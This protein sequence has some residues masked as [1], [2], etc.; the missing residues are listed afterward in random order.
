EPRSDRC[1][2]VAVLDPQVRT[3]VVLKV[4]PDRIVVGD[5]VSRHIII[6]ILRLHIFGGPADDDCKLTLIMHES[7]VVRPGRCAPVTD[8]SIRP[9]QK[10]QR[11]FRRILEG[12]LRRMVRIIETECENGLRHHRRQPFHLLLRHIASVP[13]RQAR[14]GGCSIMDPA[15]VDHPCTLQRPSPPE[16]SFS[17]LTSLVSLPMPSMSIFTTSPLPACGIISGEPASSTSPS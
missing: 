15:L 1:R 17:S 6:G 11:F 3:V 14:P 8:E 5:S 16:I 13:E 10:Y 9:L 12:Q 4:V 7:G 2:R